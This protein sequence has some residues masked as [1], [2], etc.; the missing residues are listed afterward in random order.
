MQE[1]WNQF[2]YYLCESK[3]HGVN[4]QE[5]HST[6]EAQ[7]QLL[8]W[9]SYKNE[10]CHKPNVPI[11]NS[12]FIQPDIIVQKD[13]VKLFVI[14]VKHPLH[15]QNEKDK[16]QLVSYMRQLKLNIG[17]YIG[18]RIEIFYDV[19]EDDN[20]VSL[21]VIPLELDNANGECFV[22]LFSKENYSKEAI[23]QFCEERISELRYEENLNKIKYLLV[24]D[25]QELISGAVKMFLC[26]KY[27]TLLRESDIDSLLSSFDFTASPKGMPKP[28][29]VDVCQPD[30]F[31]PELNREK[32]QRSR[33]MSRYSLNNSVFLA[34][35]RFVHRVVKLYVEQHPAAT[36]AELE[37]VFPPILQ[38]SNG[39][40]RQIKNIRDIEYVRYFMKKEELLKSGDGIVFAVCSQWGIFNVPQIV[41]LARRLGYDVKV[42]N[43]E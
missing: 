31:I 34:K 20:V 41:N 9:M 25:S 42:N 19:P 24:N 28:A 10:I 13:D 33:D 18:D 27:G 22:K 32:Q 17:I 7:L 15:T 26:D 4:E 29:V 23:D 21:L 40:I 37:R 43:A 14:E 36:Y 5:Y 12:G 35:N 39:V 1:K 8:G 6:I 30:T 11:G 38:G 3:K 2:V 16:N